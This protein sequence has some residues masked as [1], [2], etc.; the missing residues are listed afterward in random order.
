MH[1]RRYQSRII[2]SGNGCNQQIIGADFHSLTFKIRPNSTISASAIGVETNTLKWFQELLHAQFSFSWM[3]AL[4]GS[5]QQFCLNN[6]GN[7]KRFRTCLLHNLCRIRK[8]S[9]HQFNANAR[10]K[11]VHHASPQ[12]QVQ[13]SSKDASNT[14]SGAPGS[15]AAPIA[16]ASSSLKQP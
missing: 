10:I 13:S 6:K 14:L 16:S 8:A 12:N 2:G 4:L 7:A 5:H 11:K 3:T 1:I 9:A 15:R